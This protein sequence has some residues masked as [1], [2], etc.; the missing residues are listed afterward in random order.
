MEKKESLRG[1]IRQGLYDMCYIWWKEVQNL[2]K[3]EGVVI[4]FFIVPLLYPLLYSWAYNNETVRE[5]PVAVIDH[6]N[7]NMSR[8][9][10]RN[11]DASPD[12][13]VSYYCTNLDEARLLMSKQKVYGII[14]IPSEFSSNLNRMEQSHISV[15]CNMGFMLYYK[16]IFQAATSVAT[17]MN[18]KIQISKAGNFT[19][20]EDEI[21]T[22]PLA[23]EEV[24]LFNSAGGY[25]SFVIPGVLILVLQ[26]TLLLGIGLAAGTARE[27]NRY[28]NLVPV[29]RHYHGI[30]RI[31]LGKSACYAMVYAI[32]TAYEVLVVPRIFN[33]IHIGDPAAIFAIMV[34]FILACIFFGMLFSCVIRY[35]ENV[36]LLIVFTSLPFLFLTGISWPQSNIPGV[37]QGISWLIPGTFCV[38][39]FIRIN[40]MGATLRDVGFEYTILWLQVI[41]Y[42]F[43]ACLVYRRQVKLAMDQNE[44]D[45]KSKESLEPVTAP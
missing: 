15:Y 5:V 34:P 44:S 8:T 30:F 13:K 10:I 41:V 27:T 4:F 23:Y 6:C 9:F 1:R 29:S 3:D 40:S 12:V 32:I 14:H 42:F 33:F 36:I 20:Y 24:P 28:R 22:Q 18:S 21:L 19:E 16:A 37:W 38:R 17:D 43:L 2:V 39:A 7:S 45:S 11:Y 31:V 26:Q 35:R 25:G